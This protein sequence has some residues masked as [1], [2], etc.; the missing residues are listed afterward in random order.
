M[1]SR[2]QGAVCFVWETESEG[3]EVPLDRL[4]TKF[5]EMQLFKSYGRMLGAAAKRIM[6]VNTF[7]EGPKRLQKLIDERN[8]KMLK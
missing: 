1:A 6:A 4:L 2:Q 7:E 5:F 8:A 3:P